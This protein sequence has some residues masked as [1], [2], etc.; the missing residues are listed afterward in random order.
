[1]DIRVMV[2]DDSRL[3]YEEIAFLLQD[4]NFKPVQYCRTG[5][6]AVDSYPKIQ[7]DILTMDIILPDM[8]GYEAAAQILRQYQDAR[9]L[10]ISSLAY[11]DTVQKIQDLGTRSS[12]LLFKP[13]VREPLLRSLQSLYC[14]DLI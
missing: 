12:A 10:F 13:L 3:I 11:P 5:Q 4:S 9:I 1:M 6:E 2:V 7:P 8:E 14:G